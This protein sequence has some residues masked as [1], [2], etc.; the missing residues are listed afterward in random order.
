LQIEPPEL[1]LPQAHHQVFEYAVTGVVVAFGVQVDGVAAVGD[2]AQQFGRAG[3]IIL[4]CRPRLSAKLGEDTQIK[5]RLRLSFLSE[6]NGRVMATFNA[7]SSSF[8][9]LLCEVILKAPC[10]RA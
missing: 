6:Q 1:S 9:V 3:N 10:A 8:V 5:V 7:G 4:L 2:F